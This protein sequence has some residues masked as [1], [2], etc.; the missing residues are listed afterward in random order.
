MCGDLFDLD[1]IQTHILNIQYM[2]RYSVVTPF[3]KSWFYMYCNIIIMLL[4]Y[5][6]C[7]FLTVSSGLG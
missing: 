1:W 4:L 3:I 5:P 2:I 6:W 7:C